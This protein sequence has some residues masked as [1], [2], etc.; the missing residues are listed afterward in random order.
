MGAGTLKRK[1]DLDSEIAAE[2]G[3]AKKRVSRITDAFID[4]IRSHL[5]DGTVVHLDGFGKLHVHKETY[6]VR[7]QLQNP[8]GEEITTPVAVPVKHKVHFAKAQPFKLQLQQRW[9]EDNAM[10]KYGVDET[11]NQEGLEKAAAQGCPKCAA[12]LEKHGSV[13]ICPTHGSEPF[14]QK[15]NGDNKK[16]S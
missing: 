13:L 11:V 5:T 7:P 9:K 14:E 1:I 10:E 6:G 3:V 4:A 8:K 12:K 2:L 15:R 16:Q